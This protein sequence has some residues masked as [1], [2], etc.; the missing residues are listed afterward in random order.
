MNVTRE[1]ILDLLPVYL[2]GEA[3]AD[4]R[5]L[6]DE[7]LKQDLELGREIR[8]KMVENLAA[9]AAPAMPPELE[10]KTLRRTRKLL[11]K[12]RWLFGMAILFTLLPGLTILR[13]S[14]G[15]RPDVQVLARDYPWLALFS[16]LVGIV[17]WVAYYL[18]RRSSDSIL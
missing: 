14:A 13:F 1:V 16:L 9:V 8:Q 12:Q 17:L 18:T 15:R 4:T 5:K 10:L 7:Y 6:V 11:S 3:S 2:A